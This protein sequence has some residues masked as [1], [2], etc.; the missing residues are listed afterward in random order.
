MKDKVIVYNHAF[1]VAFSIDSLKEDAYDCLDKE[2]DRIKKSL[3]SRID[4]IFETDEWMEAISHCDSYE[5]ECDKDDIDLNK[6]HFDR[7]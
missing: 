6:T 4:N 3:L 1:D 5:W 7:I 2:K